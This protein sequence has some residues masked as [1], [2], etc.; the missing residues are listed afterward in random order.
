MHEVFTNKGYSSGRRPEIECDA[1][2]AMDIVLHLSSLH[3]PHEGC[4]QGQHLSATLRHTCH[5]LEA[6]HLLDGHAFDVIIDSGISWLVNLSDNLADSSDEISRVAPSPEPVQDVGMVGRT[7]RP[8]ST[9]GIRR[10]EQSNFRI[11]HAAWGYDP[12][13]SLHHGA[14]GLLLP[15]EQAVSIVR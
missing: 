15:P 6:L 8:P 9:Y 1:Q 13:A 4:W 5:A 7:R 3:D 12:T 11:E 10:I 2:L 14:V